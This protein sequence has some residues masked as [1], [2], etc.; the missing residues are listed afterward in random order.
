M[1]A[2]VWKVSVDLSPLV[3]VTGQVGDAVRASL[4]AAV[5]DVAQDAY[6]EWKDRVWK[7]HLWEGEK[8]PYFESI[9]WRFTGEFSAE[10]WSDYKNAAE[11]ET[12]RPA[13]DLKRMLD[14]SFK[15]RTSGEG[16]RYLIIPI[17]HNMDALQKAGVYQQAKKL[18]ASSVVGQGWRA[19]GAIASDVKTKK[20]FLVR[21]NTYA[22]G[23]QLKGTGHQHLEGL[24]RFNT[25]AGKG[26]SSA[27]LTFRVM[28][29][30]QPG[31]V[32]AAKPGLFLAKT[33]AQLMQH[34]ADAAFK[35]A[36]TGS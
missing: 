24:Y 23:G 5:G 17:R 36:L 33:V 10:V 28:A 15:V 30:G 22:W 32:V 16:R 6:A 21:Q 29:E 2:P 31:W 11:I 27:Y 25:S 19:S 4:R 9:G 8:T 35:K 12:G 18:T 7:A 13:R 34:R 26:K 14:T 1:A 3:L 20:Q